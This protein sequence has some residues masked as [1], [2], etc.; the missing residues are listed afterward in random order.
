MV[1]VRK[2]LRFEGFEVLL[3]TDKGAAAIFGITIVV[4]QCLFVH[5]PVRISSLA[6][7]LDDDSPL[8]VDFLRIAGH[9]M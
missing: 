9:E 6:S 8:R 3:A 7:F 1:E 2:A 5:S 4:W